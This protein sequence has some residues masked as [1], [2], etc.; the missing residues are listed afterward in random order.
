MLAA[1]AVSYGP[2]EIAKLSF[3]V[4]FKIK[5]FYLNWRMERMARRLYAQLQDD[6]KALGLEPLPPFS[7]K[8]LE[9][10]YGKE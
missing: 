6:R 5:V 3:W 9:R 7:W 2:Q 4:E 1:L 8:A 10:R